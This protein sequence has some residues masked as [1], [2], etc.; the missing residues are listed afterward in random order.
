MSNLFAAIG[1]VQ[2]KRFEKEFKPRRIELAR[3]Y[4]S[5]LCNV[6]GLKLIECD[7]SSIVPHIF[8]II[9]LDGKRNALRQFLTDNGIECGIH[10]KPNH[11]LSFYGAKKE[12]LPVTEKLYE[13]LLTL[14]LHP[15]LTDEEADYVIEKVIKFFS[16]T[17]SQDKNR[18]AGD[19]NYESSY[20]VRR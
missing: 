6:P 2:L 12:M 7:P 18:L 17:E 1:R 19:R 3:R 9:V 20:S 5:A 13:Q 8:P 15:G 16:T 4:R 14:P 11:L 10:Y